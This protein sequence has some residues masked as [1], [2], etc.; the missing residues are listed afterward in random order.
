MYWIQQRKFHLY[1]STT[2]VEA[3]INHQSGL[4]VNAPTGFGKT[5]LY[6]LVQSFNSINNNPTDFFNKKKQRSVLL[7]TTPLRAL[8]KDIERNVKWWKNLNGLENWFP[9]TEIPQLLKEPNKKRQL[10][11][12]LI[13]TPESLHLFLAKKTIP[14]HLKI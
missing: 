11:E 3:N 5:Y 6:F 1:F 8:A 10:P 12:V 14:I 13:I 2:N 4:V 9:K 7:V